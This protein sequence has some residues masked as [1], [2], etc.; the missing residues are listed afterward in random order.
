MLPPPS[1]AVR[2]RRAATLQRAYEAYAEAYA[3]AQAIDSPHSYHAAKTEA[4]RALLRAER[5]PKAIEL[6]AKYAQLLRKA[7]KPTESTAPQPRLFEDAWPTAFA[8]IAERFPRRPYVSDNLSYTTVRALHQAVGWRYVQYDPPAYHHVLVVDYDAKD[9]KALPALEVWRAAGLPT[10]TWVACT[11]DTPRGH[12]AWAL[13]TPVCG[14]SLARLGPLQYLA[15]IEQAYRD[16]IKGDDGYAATLTKNPVHQSWQ[17]HWLDSTLRSLDE[18]AAAVEL[19]KP[20][21]RKPIEMAPITA[22][23]RKVGTFEAVRKWAYSSVPQYWEEGETAWYQAVREQVEAVNRSFSEPLPESHR[24]SIS[25]SIAKW[26]WRRFTPLSKHQLVVATHQPAVQAMRGRLKG[27]AVREQHMATA[28]AR[29]EAGESAEAIGKELG[30]TART[31][32]NWRQRSGRKKPI[33]D[34]SAVGGFPKAVSVPMSQGP[35]I[36]DS[37][38]NS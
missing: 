11:P 20:S 38:L 35:G 28:L 26:V 19:P 36:Q 22:L 31:L 5:C 14:T 6:Q 15:A 13:S 16:A 21:R 37:F 1:A 24:R 32:L 25:K 2:S 33:S 8:P 18:L 17:V 4:E 9:D 12:L 27:A 29:L 7:T 23:G 3:S 34:N 30:V 10:P